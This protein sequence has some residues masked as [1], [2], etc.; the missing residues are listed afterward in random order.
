[1]IEKS[2]S[3]PFSSLTATEEIEKVEELAS[4]AGSI[5]DQCDY[6]LLVRLRKKLPTTDDKHVMWRRIKVAGSTKLFA[7]QDKILAPALGWVRNYHGY[8]FVDD[9]DGAIFGPAGGMV[10]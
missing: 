8:L 10:S 4:Q 5:R 7:F 2:V 9:K 6:V 1:M 3:R